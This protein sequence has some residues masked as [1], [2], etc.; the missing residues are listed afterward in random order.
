VKAQ[1]RL[2]QL[3][4]LLLLLLLLL[5]AQVDAQTLT[6]AFCRQCFGR[7]LAVNEV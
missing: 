1:G 3:P 5:C 2:W 4:V 7:M 6:K